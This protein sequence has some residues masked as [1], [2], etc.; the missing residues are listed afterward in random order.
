MFYWFEAIGAVIAKWIKLGL[1]LIQIGK[2]LLYSRLDSS[3]YLSGTIFQYLFGIE[4]R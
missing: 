4:G 3:I 2:K 1:V